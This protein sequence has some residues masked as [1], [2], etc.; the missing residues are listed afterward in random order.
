M[1]MKTRRGFFCIIYRK[2]KNKIQYLLLKRK[3]HWKGWEFLKGGIEKG[4]SIL[5]SL[6]REIKEETGQKPFNIKKHKLKGKYKYNGKLVDRT[7]ITHQSYVLY[8]A[9]I[10]DVNMKIDKREHSGY[11]W[12]DYKKALELL[13]WPNQKKCLRYFNKK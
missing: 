10:E 1:N 11:R 6:K 13:T 12:V 7:K 8:S 3:L 4:E 9:E 2:E 5:E